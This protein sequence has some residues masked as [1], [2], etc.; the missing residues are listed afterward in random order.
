VHGRGSIPGR[1]KRLCFTASRPALRPTK[2]PI[3]WVLE[4]LF[5]GVKRQGFEADHSLSSSAEIK[6]G[7]AISPFPYISS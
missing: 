1:G 7:G 4:T 6:N 2:S 5:P 3:Q